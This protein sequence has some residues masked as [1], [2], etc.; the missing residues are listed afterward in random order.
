MQII[1]LGLFTFF[2]GIGSGAIYSNS[3]P[4]DVTIFPISLDQKQENRKQE[5]IGFL[6]YWLLNFARDSYKGSLTN[7]SYFSLTIDEDGT[8]QKKVNLQEE[9]PGWTTLKKET[10]KE[11]FRKAK[12]D[13]LST[14]LTVFASTESHIDTL[15]SDPVHHAQNLV[16]DITPI[17]K[18][19]S[20]TDL[21]LDIESVVEASASSQQQFTDFARTLK[22]GL[23]AN[24]LGT[25]TV[26]MTVMSLFQTQR[27][28]PRDIADISDRVILMT[29][30]YHYAGSHLAG[31][32]SPL[33]GADTERFNDVT[34]S[35]RKALEFIPKE[36]LLLGIPLYGYEWEVLGSEPGSPVIPRTGKTASDRRVEELLYDCEECITGRDKSGDEPYVIFPDDSFF[37][38][39]YYTDEISLEKKHQLAKE[40]GIAGVAYWAMGYEGKK[41]LE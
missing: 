27:M 36:K 1:L 3:V 21:N 8:I 11:R 34:V 9:E 22:N 10:V 41:T 24:N 39:I 40:L 37:H 25:L 14:S 12:Q 16:N 19:F 33:E 15:L 38:Q 13:G 20:F 28:N 29:Y 32:V 31:P 17:M 7:L 30:D 6:P 2:L 35:I 26:D 23:T 5:V 4:S 18:E